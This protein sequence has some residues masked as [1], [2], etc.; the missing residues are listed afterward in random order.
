MISIA[1]YFLVVSSGSVLGVAVWKRRFTEILPVSCGFLVL[2]LFAAGLSGNLKA[3]VY[4]LFVIAGGIYLFSVWYAVSHREVKDSLKRL[5][6]A[7]TAVF[8]GLALLFLCC[9]LGMEATGWDEFSH[10]MDTVKTMTLIDDL[11]TSPEAHVLFP[12]YPPGLSLFHYPLQIIHLLTGG[13]E[14]SEWRYLFSYKLFFLCMIAPAF[15]KLDFR[16][17]LAILFAF[18]SSLIFPGVFFGSFYD[19]G[20]VDSFLGMMSGVGLAY[21][22]IYNGENERVLKRLSV[23]TASMIL[24]LTKD[25]GLLF[26]VML[27]LGVFAAEFLTKNSDSLISRSV[28]CLETAAAFAIPKIAWNLHLRARGVNRVFSNPIL[29][30]D[31]SQIILQKDETWRQD[32]WNLFFQKLVSRKTSV[33][34]FELS[35]FSCFLIFLGLAVLLLVMV[36]RNKKDN[37]PTAR[38]IFLILFFQT[39]IYIVGLGVEYLFQFG[40]YEGSVHASYDRYMG[41]AF[42]GILTVLQAVALDLFTDEARLPKMETAAALSLS[43]VLLLTPMDTVKAYLTKETVRESYAFRYDYD[44]FC[45]V[46]NELALEGNGWL[47]SQHYQGG[48]VKVKC[49]LKPFQVQTS[50]FSFHDSPIYDNQPEFDVSPEDWMNQLSDS[51]DYVLLY[52]ADDYFRDNYGYLFEEPEKI[53]DQSFFS[54]DRE[55]R[56]LV[57]VGKVE[58]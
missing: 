52:I 54:V 23:C 25:A 8:V 47:I 56:K 16:N 11:G 17:P 53:T 42:L 2:L 38:S 57:Y 37:Y 51:Y 29:F 4:L 21:L 49:I 48:Y 12:S 9:N 3:G 36:Y 32:S 1:F 55:N 7:D 43:V 39:V 24:V 19:S 44:K 15:R 31:L 50:L 26:A 30:G 14:F 22:I 40:E 6:A 45:S 35:Y 5:F 41:V 33:G 46:A 13:K 58:N 10:W 20:L 18:S 34:C 27:L 28:F